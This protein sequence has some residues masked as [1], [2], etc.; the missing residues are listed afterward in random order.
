MK[1]PASKPLYIPIFL[2]NGHEPVDGARQKK[3]EVEPVHNGTFN[4]FH[5]FKSLIS[6]NA[7][8][9]LI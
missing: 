6:P 8:N 9:R 5:V 1:L 3:H 7:I 4:L 2:P